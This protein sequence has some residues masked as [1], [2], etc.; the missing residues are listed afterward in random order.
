M[1][2]SKQ[3]KQTKKK[4]NNNK[5]TYDLIDHLMLGLETIIAITSMTFIID[6]DAYELHL[7]DE[8]SSMTLLMNARVLQNRYDWGWLL[9]KSKFVYLNVNDYS[10][11]CNSLMYGHYHSEL[12][13]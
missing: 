5:W 6:L 1:L 8:K 7:R 9:F 10:D 2:I 11:E 13:Y 3:N 4:N 12:I